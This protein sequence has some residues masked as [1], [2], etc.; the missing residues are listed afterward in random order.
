M[1]TKSRNRIKALYQLFNSSI[2]C[3]TL[4]NKG[5][6][7]Q[8]K[9]EKTVEYMK[10]SPLGSRFA[11]AIIWIAI[12]FVLVYNLITD[13]KLVLNSI[14]LGI[15]FVGSI[16]EALQRFFNILP[17]IYGFIFGLSMLTSL[18]MLLYDNITPG[19]LPLYFLIWEQNI[20]PAVAI[21]S[22]A[23]FTVTATLTKW[24]VSIILLFLSLIGTLVIISISHGPTSIFYNKSC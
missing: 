6:K 7:Y 16:L 14:S 19:I 3:I 21:M 24:V 2:N 13:Q 23:L 4:T 22:I 9:L 11:L 17:K 20:R 8:H 1:N 15:F 12:L 10:I 5:S 18:L